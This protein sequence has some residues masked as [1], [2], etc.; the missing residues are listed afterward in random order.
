MSLRQYLSDHELRPSA[1]KEQVRDII[2]KKI[3]G[4]HKAVE[5]MGFGPV[6]FTGAMF[7]IMCYMTKEDQMSLPSFW[8]N[9]FSISGTVH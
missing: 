6:V 8:I 1:R 9:V 5:E 7:G 3:E 2:D 4:S